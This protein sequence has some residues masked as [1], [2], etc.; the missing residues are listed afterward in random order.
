ML[1]KH[2]QIGLLLTLFLSGTLFSEAQDPQKLSLNEAVIMAMQYNT[3]MMNSKLDLEIAHKKIWETT[4][5]GLPHADITSAYTGCFHLINRIGFNLV[6]QAC[7]FSRLAVI[8]SC[9]A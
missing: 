5:M 9:P 3:S 2:K 7:S 8:Q 6:Y 1:R 4:A